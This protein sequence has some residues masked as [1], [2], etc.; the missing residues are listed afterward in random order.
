H[1]TKWISTHGYALNVDLDPAPFTEWITACGLDGFAFTSMARELGRSVA[2]DD[3]RP[4]AAQALADVFG[5]VLTDVDQTRAACRPPRV[6]RKPPA[7]R[8]RS[9]TATPVSRAPAAASTPDAGV[10]RASSARVGRGARRAP[11]R[12]RSRP[13]PIRA[14][15]LPRWRGGRARSAAASTPRRRAGRPASRAARAATPSAARA[16]RRA[17]PTRPGGRPT[18]RRAPPPAPC[19]RAAAR[20]PARP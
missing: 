15:S 10:P 17:S 18:R 14:R 4:A 1:L 7:E 20:P 16:A 5:L 12:R 11:R 9:C 6:R 2:V 13:G 8:R 3:V 19:A